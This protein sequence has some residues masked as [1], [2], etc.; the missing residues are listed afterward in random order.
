[1]TTKPESHEESIHEQ[2]ANAKNEIKLYANDNGEVGSISHA[3][4][5]LWRYELEILKRKLRISER[6]ESGL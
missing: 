1:M 5:K 3:Q 6:E 2:I 4:L